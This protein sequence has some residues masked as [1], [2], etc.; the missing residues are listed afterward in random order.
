MM[1]AADEVIILADSTKFGHSSLA[2]L[3]DLEQ[4]DAMVVDTGIDAVWKQRLRDAN[5]RLYVAGDV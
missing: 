1:Q 2:R 3:C 5:V 4:I